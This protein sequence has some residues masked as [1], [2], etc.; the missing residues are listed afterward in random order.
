MSGRKRKGA[1]TEKNQPASSLLVHQ[2]KKPKVDSSTMIPSQSS[3]SSSSSTSSPSSS[4]SS[5]FLA[6]FAKIKQQRLLLKTQVEPYKAKRE[7]PKGSVSV[8]WTA[9]NVREH[10]LPLV[11]KY[12]GKLLLC[13]FDGDD[14]GDDDEEIGTVECYKINVNLFMNEGVYPFDFVSYVYFGSCG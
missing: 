13:S 14:D 5:T 10:H 11:L 4:P 12:E 1:G 9:E 8:R 7:V 2:A 6:E 3:S